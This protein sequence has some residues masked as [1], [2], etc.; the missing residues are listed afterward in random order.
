M[1]RGRRMRGKV[2]QHGAALL[3][4]LLL[5]TLAEHGLAAWLVQP[6]IEG[7]LAAMLGIGARRHQRPAGQNVGEAD[8]IILGVAGAHTELM[9]L[10]DLARKILV[11]AAAAV[12]AGD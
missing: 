4:I 9:Q 1:G 2:T 10:H 8:D 11:E 3:H 5:V 12:G 7:E 6:R